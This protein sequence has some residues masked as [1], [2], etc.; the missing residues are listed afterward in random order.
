MYSL[1]KFTLSDMT[2]CGAVLR[3]LGVGATSMEE[4]ANRAVQYLYDHFL[5]EHTGEPA[6]ALARFFKTHPYAKLSEPL[7][8]IAQTLEGHHAISPGTPCLT[9]LATTG[10]KPEWRSRQAS[11]GH[12]VI[13]LVSEQLVAQSPMI[14]QLI[15]QFGLDVSTVLSPNPDLLVD[16]EQKTFNVFHVANAI[17]SPYVP[18]QDSFVV[19]YGIRSVL[20]F[21]GMLPSGNLIAIILFSKVFISRDTA[22]MF[23]TLALNVKMAALP[24]DRGQVFA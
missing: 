19:P 13:P 12:Q 2:E 17:A 23:K 22:A 20:G 15:Q 6:L 1:T 8:A 4:V 9:L 24:F 5:D 18:A 11:T 14:S 16:L 21:G 7:H 3:K 10:Q